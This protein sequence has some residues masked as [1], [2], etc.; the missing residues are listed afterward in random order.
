MSFRPPSLGFLYLVGVVVCFLGFFAYIMRPMWWD[1]RPK[2]QRSH[3]EAA[4]L[5]R[6]VTDGPVSKRQAWL[7]DALRLYVSVGDLD[8]AARILATAERFE[9]T[10]RGDVL[11]EVEPELCWMIGAAP[12]HWV[13]VDGSVGIYLRNDSAQQQIVRLH[14]TS[15]RNGEGA[16]RARGED[17]SRFE[18]NKGKNAVVERTLQSGAVEL[19]QAR[20][21]S[22]T[23]NEHQGEIGMRLVRVEVVS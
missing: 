23:S 15:M 16:V 1:L 11:V 18:L 13:Q 7:S 12:T 8:G 19:L 20:V 14:W 22:S 2:R 4:Y 6:I 3:A 5:E 21:S 17:W 9:V 10:I